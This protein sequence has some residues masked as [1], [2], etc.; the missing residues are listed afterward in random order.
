LQEFALRAVAVVDPARTPCTQLGVGGAHRVAARG[1]GRPLGDL[2]CGALLGGGL[3]RCP[4]RRRRGR[5]QHPLRGRVR[6]HR[7]E[8]GITTYWLGG[9]DIDLVP[10]GVDRKALGQWRVTTVHGF[11][12]LGRSRPSRT[13]LGPLL[14]PVPGWFFACLL[15]GELSA[16]VVP[17]HHTHQTF[18]RCGGYFVGSG[19]GLARVPRQSTATTLTIGVADSD[20][21]GARGAGPHLC[22][23]RSFILHSSVTGR[24]ELAL[25]MSSYRSV[26]RA[27]RF[28]RARQRSSRLLRTAS[29]VNAPPSRS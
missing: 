25:S 8:E 17:G 21:V 12:A 18:L 3:G 4:V 1:R 5:G 7:R 9:H 28:A 13:V 11:V 10:F 29:S 15:L 2:L 14:V 22:H 16:F 27:A 6:V 24:R 26:A 19:R 23:C 20:P